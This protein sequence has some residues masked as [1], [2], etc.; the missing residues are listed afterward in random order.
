MSKKKYK[1]AIESFDRRIA[2]HEEKRR[3]AKSP[4]LFGYWTKEIER[5]EREKKKKQEKL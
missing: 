1:R 2:E 4:E 5:F 3:T